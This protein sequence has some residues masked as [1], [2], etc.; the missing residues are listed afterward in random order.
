MA[1]ALVVSLGLQ[2]GVGLGADDPRHFAW[3]LLLTTAVTTVVWLAVTLATPPEPVERLRAFYAR[4]RP[5]GA[6]WR[7]V[8]PDA[9]R[10]ARLAAG[11]RQWLAGCAVVYLGL[12]G[13]GG[14]VLGRPVSGALALV[15]AAALTAYIVKA[16]DTAAPGKAADRVV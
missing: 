2:F 1:A 6:G 16:T 11:L 3:L 14:L 10:D 15:V 4:V 7:A 13:I 8:V 12:F 5:G 9:D